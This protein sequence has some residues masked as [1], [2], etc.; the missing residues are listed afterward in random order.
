M[1]GRKMICKNLQETLRR[2]MKSQKVSPGAP[3]MSTKQI[4]S[5]YKV[6]F[7]TA[8]NAVNALAEK[9]LLYR[10]RGSGT[11]VAEQK[12]DSVGKSCS[13]GI[14][15]AFSFHHNYV[16][17]ISFG[18]FL[19]PAAEKL[20]D[21]NCAVKYFSFK[22]FHCA[23]KFAGIDGLIVSY[24]CVDESTL[25]VLNA[26]SLPVVLVQ[27]EYATD[28]SY[29]QVIP[30]LG[31]GF[32]KAAAHLFDAGHRSLYVA[33]NDARHSR[34][35]VEAFLKAAERVG[36]ECKNIFPVIDEM[37]IGD[38]GRILGQKIA[39]K[40]LREKKSRAVLSTSD[41]ISFGIL[42]RVFD[43]GLVPGKD[44]SIV[45][46]DD[47]ESDGLCPFGKPILTSVRNPRKGISILAGELLLDVIRKNDKC[48]HIIKVPMDLS[49]R[50][51]SMSKS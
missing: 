44:I 22:D 8:N 50:E 13:I 48:L 19:S 29:N 37:I 26:L 1:V 36:F 9:G 39:D 20:S 24:S 46:Y 34:T 40:I 42:D 43:A 16:D 12:K 6:S 14:V 21:L 17:D 28:I 51:S 49:I 4:A 30:D 45:S 33:S 27:H 10:E 25:K 11:F 41:F 23:R 7:I 15:S 3:F 35:R 31:S 18:M 5:K 32:K 47:L 2:E 38:N